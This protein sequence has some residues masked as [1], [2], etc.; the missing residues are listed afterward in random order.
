MASD[1]QHPRVSARS[2]ATRPRDVGAL[3]REPM[4][5]IVRGLDRCLQ[6][7]VH[8]R[9]TSAASKP[10]ASLTRRLSALLN[11]RSASSISCSCSAIRVAGKRR[12]QAPA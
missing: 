10:T 4:A 5:G 8:R 7:S 6:R 11:A 3:Q 12:A 1:R 2:V 9:R